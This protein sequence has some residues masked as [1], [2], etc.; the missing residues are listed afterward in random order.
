MGSDLEKQ[1]ED[2]PLTFTD[3]ALAFIATGAAQER[4]R[5]EIWNKE[6]PLKQEYLPIEIIIGI[7]GGGCAGFQYVTRFREKEDPIDEEYHTIS[8]NGIT[9]HMDVYST[10]YLQ[11]TIL[12]YVKTMQNEGLVFRNPNA[13]R[14]CGCGSSFGG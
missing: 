12:D 8:K 5:R 1:V 13:K 11:G 7:Q 14:T 6:H 2:F 4:A 9:F 10:M 3:G